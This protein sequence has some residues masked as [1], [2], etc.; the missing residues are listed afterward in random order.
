[1]GQVVAATKASALIAE[2]LS[3]SSVARELGW[4]RRRCWGGCGQPMKRGSVGRRRAGLRYLPA[5]DD[6]PRR[7]KG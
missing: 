3:T 7:V 1:M 4:Q 2:G 5:Y 6:D